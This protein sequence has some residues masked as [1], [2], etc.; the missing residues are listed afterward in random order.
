MYILNIL[1]WFFDFHNMD[2]KEKPYLS[3]QLHHGSAKDGQEDYDLAATRGRDQTPYIATGSNK[4]RGRLYR[5][6]RFACT[7]R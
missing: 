2:H 1:N 4:C 7:V 6:Q 3:T 5:R